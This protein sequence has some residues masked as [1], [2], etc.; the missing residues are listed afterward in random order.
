MMMEMEICNACEYGVSCKMCK[1]YPNGDYVC[2]ECDHKYSIQ[3]P[4]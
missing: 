4:F 3:H 1:P 2:A